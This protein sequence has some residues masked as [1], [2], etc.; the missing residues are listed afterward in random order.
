MKTSLK[1][2]ALAVVIISSLGGVCTQA[3][4]AAFA[5]QEQSASGLG[6]AFAGGAAE[7]ADASSMFANP[8]TLSQ[9]KSKQVISAMH[10]ATPSMT[11]HHERSQP[12][13]NQP[14]GNEGGDSGS[15]NFLG[16]F[17]V[18]LPINDRWTAGLGM[19][20]PFGLETDYNNTWAGR[21]LALRSAVKTL[22]VNP[23]VS[24]K[25]TE[26]L[27][28]GIGVNWQYVHAIFTSAVNYS[29]ALASA[30]QS[31]AAAGRLP[32]DMLPAILGATGGLDS[33]SKVKGHNNAWGWNA[34]LLYEFDP[35][36]R[37][38]LSYRSE[39]KHKV[40][41]TV[42]FN[43]PSLGNVPAALAPIVGGIADGVNNALHDGKIH[44]DITLPQNANLSFFRQVTPKLDLMADIQWTG[45][46][47]LKELT[48]IRNEGSVLQS[49]PEWFKNTWRVSLGGN[50]RFNERW[51]MRAGVAYDQS[52]VRD[53][54]RT[55]RLP[56]VDRYWISLGG[57]YAINPQM[58]IDAG[59][60]YLF[61]KKAPIR[62]NGGNPQANGALDGYYK[63]YATV[64]SVQFTYTF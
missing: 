8:A 51:L 5:L 37:V 39:V 38:G 55:P 9:R 58:H 34:G 41:G 48:F 40:N 57:Q 60:T 52:P 15:A 31:A 10:I 22:N 3:Q 21:Y 43:H 1:K 46:S 61:G 17:Y 20:T 7:G 29:A 44:A 19:G 26:Q 13:F 50:Y 63:N 32:P 27:S 12:A 59:F 36:T 28:L 33:I 49:T 23:A 14:L 35:S 54:Y 53:T 30:A 42:T 4:A 11:F 45:W 6:N 62:D 24:F 56:D 47:S 18:A 2:S 64:A 25:A 16:N